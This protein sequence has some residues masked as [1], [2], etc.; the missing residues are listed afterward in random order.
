MLATASS[1]TAISSVVGFH[2]HHTSIGTMPL[3]LQ[4]GPVV[5]ETFTW[6]DFPIIVH[7]ERDEQIIQQQKQHQQ[8]QDHF[9]DHIESSPESP[10]SRMGFPP[11]PLRCFSVSVSVLA[12]DASPAKKSVVRNKKP[13]KAVRFAP[14]LEIR[15]HSRVLGDHPWC[16][17][18]LALGL[19]WDHNDSKEACKEQDERSM[20]PTK[21][22]VHHPR[23]LSYWERK[24]LLVEVA[25]C[26]EEELQASAAGILDVDEA[27]YCNNEEDDLF[28]GVGF[29]LENLADRHQPRN[30]SSSHQQLKQRQ[31]QQRPTPMA[32]V[33]SVTKCLSLYAAMA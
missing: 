15:T 32:R 31:H 10:S 6:S 13:A 30:V 25:G 21:G 22:A 12:R 20:P 4:R 18:G 28:V 8:Q 33:G 23:P 29:H 16:E 9:C 14:F 26:R 27:E 11:N 5:M 1:T 19:G 7:D 3:H 2:H 17:D 24:R